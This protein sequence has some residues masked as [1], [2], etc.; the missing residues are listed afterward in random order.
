MKHR[1]RKKAAKI[2][3]N[4]IKKPKTVIDIKAMS[5]P[6][7]SKKERNNIKYAKRK[8]RLLAKLEPVKKAA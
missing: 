8:A 6:M 1:S 3:S 7:R 5:W 2:L 4:R